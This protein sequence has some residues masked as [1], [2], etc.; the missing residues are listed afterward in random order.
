MSDPN[1]KTGQ[2]FILIGILF[3]HSV[4]TIMDRVAISAAKDDIIA[5]LHISD[6]MMG[7]I[8]GIFA[9]GYA[10][11][12][13][14]AGAFADRYGP[15][16]ALTWVV[17]VWSTFTM[18]TGSAF[19][20]VGMLILRF[21]FGA[22]EAG[23][24][25]GATRAF[26]SWLPVKERGIAHGINFSGS[27]IGAALSLFLMPS[28]IILVGWRWTFVLNGLVGIVWAAVW[29]IWFR[30][31]P[32]DN[33]KIGPDELKYI[34]EG[35]VEE[36]SSEDKGTFG[37]IFI[38]RNMLLAMFQYLSSN[39][40]FFICFSWLLPY[41]TSTWGDEV[42]AYHAPI[43]LLVGAC[44]NWVSGGLVSAIYKKWGL[45]A[46]RRVPA[47]VG[48]LLGTV[49]L[50]AATQTNQLDLFILSFSIAVFGVDMTL[51]PSWSFCMDIGGKLS[52]SISASMNMVGNIGSALSAIIFPY[53]VASVTIPFFAPEAGSGNS[54]FIFCGVLNS[55]SILA[56]MLMNPKRDVNRT[57]S[58]SAVKFRVTLLAVGITAATIGA[59]VYK[60]FF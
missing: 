1:K 5:D 7:Y 18:L 49:G 36:G 41:V 23:A 30:D 25:P 29:L 55:L 35:R 56:W 39:M 33:K 59:I 57:L 53:F 20:T 9:L 21:L 34:E 31:S 13:V 52:G 8:F 58:A 24:Y 38:S 22:G 14:P 51:S 2:R 11:F 44:A 4:N 37:Q 19:N 46:S 54:F 27:R 60:V 26:F 6:Q 10:L 50:I 47:I 43:P 28:L 17:T 16:K 40:T 42:K 15:R 32:G 48:F 3:F 12:Q 45:V